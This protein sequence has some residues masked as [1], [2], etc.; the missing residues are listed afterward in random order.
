MQA[1]ED[2]DL[3]F[4]LAVEELA[5]ARDI[6]AALRTTT[7]TTRADELTALEREGLPADGGVLVRERLLELV[8]EL[9]DT[10]G[11]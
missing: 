11:A 10:G 1:L 4:A 6:V 5:R 2:V 9:L 7:S 3:R 8:D